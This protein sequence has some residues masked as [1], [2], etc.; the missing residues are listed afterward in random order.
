VPASEHSFRDT[1]PAQMF[2]DVDFFISVLV[3]TEPHH[4]RSTELFRRLAARR[5][6]LFVSSLTWMEFVNVVIKDR[7]RANLPD[8]LRSQLNL[9]RWQRSSVRRQ[10]LDLLLQRLKELLDQFPWREVWLTPE[11]RELA[12]HDILNFNL[13]PLD[14]VMR[15]SATYVGVSDFASFDE[16]YRRV[17]GLTLW[18]D[19]IHAG[20]PIRG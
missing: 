4:Q 2:L 11:V 3:R 9:D 16:A 6:T 15:A 12:V 10:Y 14:A 1:V 19:L 5:T 18:N 7:F 8:S 17:D 13:R 20:K